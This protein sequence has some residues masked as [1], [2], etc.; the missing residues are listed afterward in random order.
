MLFPMPLFRFL[1][2]QPLP[3]GSPNHSN[4]AFAIVHLTVVPHEIELPQIA[5]KVLFADVVIDSVDSAL[6]DC[7]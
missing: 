1:I 7:K 4:R 2:S 5:V 6:H 3:F